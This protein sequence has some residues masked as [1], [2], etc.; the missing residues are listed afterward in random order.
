MITCEGSSDTSDASTTAA[1][2]T[3]FTLSGCSENYCKLPNESNRNTSMY[4]YTGNKKTEL[5]NLAENQNGKI[6]LR[7][8]NFGGG[9]TLQKCAPWTTGT[10]QVACNWG[11]LESTGRRAT[12]GTCSVEQT[13]E[14]T[15]R[16][17][18]YLTREKC[19][20]ANGVWT[21][22]TT[23]VDMTEARK[24]DGDVPEFTFTGC[25]PLVRQEP[26]GTTYYEPYPGDC[27][28]YWPGSLSHI[29]DDGSGRTI[30]PPDLP[31]EQSRDTAMFRF[32]NQCKRNCDNNL[33]CSGFTIQKLGRDEAAAS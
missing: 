5:E 6:T 20:G 29:S 13:D 15:G 23:Q 1:D 26:E 11:G 22:E 16:K 21:P 3:K 10:P 30:S 17:I 32:Y 33:K 27:V 9:P 19:E 25:V 7:Q 8:F 18:P 24:P 2:T 4:T 28:G 14:V 31:D 12:A